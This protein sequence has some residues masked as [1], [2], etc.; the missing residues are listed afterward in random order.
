MRPSGVKDDGSPRYLPF[1]IIGGV[2]GDVNHFSLCPDAKHWRK[3]GRPNPV[4][5]A[6]H[7]HVFKG[8]QIVLE[9]GQVFLKQ[10]CSVAGCWETR[11]RPRGAYA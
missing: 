4:E 9:G 8:G 1:E 6:V 7:E 11:E 2:A 5:E 10:A 3:K